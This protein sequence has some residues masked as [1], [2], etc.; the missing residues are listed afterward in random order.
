MGKCKNAAKGGAHAQKGASPTP[1]SHG[2]EVG[3][4]GNAVH[5]LR[6]DMASLE[7]GLSQIGAPSKMPFIF[8]QSSQL[9]SEQS[10]SPEH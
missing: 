3:D 5:D 7:E 4:T 10:L 8:T 1:S 6:D 9:P 2:G